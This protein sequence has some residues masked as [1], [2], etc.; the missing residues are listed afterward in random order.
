VVRAVGAQRHLRRRAE[1]ERLR[2]TLRWHPTTR[3]S[4]SRPYPW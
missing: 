1:H 3:A 4:R 2:G